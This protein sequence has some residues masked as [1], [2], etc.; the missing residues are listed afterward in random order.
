MSRVRTIHPMLT[1]L[2]AATLFA[3]C[4]PSNPPAAKAPT[5]PQSLPTSLFLAAAPA[6]PV[7]IRDAKQAVKQGDAVVLRGVVGGGR[8]PFVAGRAVVMLVD[9]RVKS[10]RD[11]PEDTCAT[12]WDYCCE[13]REELTANS[14]TVQVVGP[15]G[16]PLASGLKDAG[17]LAPLTR[18]IVVGSVA[19]RDDSGTFIV[20]ATG[21][22]IETN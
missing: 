18:M 5:T 21:L 22:F 17:G 14:V 2:V 20:N 15:D 11:N 4:G 10:C 8:D 1:L 7:E 12:P 19:Q 13:P 16:R 6:S 9:T 3:S